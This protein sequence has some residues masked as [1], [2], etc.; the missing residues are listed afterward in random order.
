MAIGALLYVVALNG[1]ATTRTLI[2]DEAKQCGGKTLEAVT[3]TE[4]VLMTVTTP[5][6]AIAGVATIIG[7]AITDAQAIACIVKVAMDDL[8]AKRSVDGGMAPAETQLRALVT[9]V[10]AYPTDPVAHGIA[11][12]ND[13]LARLG[14]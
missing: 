9:G 7:A 11:V 10:Y 13:V 5:E 12:G 1:C 8:R 2:A 14:K 4:G 3:Q 6:A